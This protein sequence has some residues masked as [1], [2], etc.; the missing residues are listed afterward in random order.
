MNIIFATRE[1]VENLKE[2]Y[3]VLELDS[4]R[5]SQGKDTVVSW[6]IIDTTSVL[7]GELPGIS[8]YVDLHNNM[9]R[10]YRSGNFKYCEDALEHLIGKWRGELD[11]FYAIMSQRIKQY[12]QDP[13]NH[14]WDGVI[15][16][17]TQD[18]AKNEDV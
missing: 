2:K 17:T 1:E 3:I 8:Q 16:R 14:G 5:F 9:M 18:F 4:F 13:P 12:Q 7:L 10:N 11:S 15:D 6:S